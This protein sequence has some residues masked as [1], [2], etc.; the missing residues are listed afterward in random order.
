MAQAIA[1]GLGITIGELRE[2]GKQ[3]KLSAQTVFEALQSQAG[4]LEEEFARTNRTIGQ[5][6]TILEN[7]G[8][9][10]AGIIN[11][12][13]GA[14]ESLG[15]AIRDVAAA[16]D[17]I[18]ESDV[19]FYMDVLTGTIGAIVDV[20]TNVIDKIQQFI[21]QDDEVLGYAS[22]FAKIRLGVELLSASIQFLTDLIADSFCRHGL[23]SLGDHIQN[24]FGRH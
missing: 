19:A 2:Y 15:G 20:F 14:N 8:I 11:N 23:P 24:H 12:V 22:I 1:D 13:A 21:S 10:L 9:R 18:T 17:A 3:G 5:S 7:S 16:L 4:V 6:F